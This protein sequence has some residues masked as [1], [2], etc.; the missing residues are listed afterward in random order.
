MTRRS[1]F[2]FLLGAQAGQQAGQAQQYA[3]IAVQLPWQFA[4]AEQPLAAPNQAP[5][6][7]N[8]LPA[9]GQYLV[10]HPPNPPQSLQLTR[11]GLTLLQGADY[12][13]L[14]NQ[15][16]F[17]PGALPQPGDNLQAWYRY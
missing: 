11:N 2:A 17:L 15:I 16:T 8:Q 9:S 13:L 5:S 1:F 7:P 12:T 6:Q 4:D 10:A 3:P 14:S